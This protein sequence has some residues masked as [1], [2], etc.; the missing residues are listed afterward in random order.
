MVGSVCCYRY[1]LYSA[2]SFSAGDIIVDTKVLNDLWMV[3]HV[4]RTGKN[5]LL[6]S[7]YVE[8]L[9]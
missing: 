4:Q 1:L 7:N 8:P 3:G 5:G 6:P 2:Y 9:V